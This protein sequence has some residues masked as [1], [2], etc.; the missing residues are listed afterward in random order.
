MA[1]IIHF[2]NLRRKMCKKCKI[3]FATV[4]RTEISLCL[5]ILSS[6][7]FNVMALVARLEVYY[8]EPVCD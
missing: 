5:T 3:L 1:T 6:G 4:I 7:Q 8:T 2:K